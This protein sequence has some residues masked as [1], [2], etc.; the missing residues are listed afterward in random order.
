MQ[1]LRHHQEGIARLLTERR[2]VQ[3]RA[4]SAE[5]IAHG[6]DVLLDDG[7]QFGVRLE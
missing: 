7:E 4:G 1:T 6:S 3:F 5:V 2:L